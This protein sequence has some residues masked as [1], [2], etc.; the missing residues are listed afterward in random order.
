FLRRGK[1]ADVLPD[2]EIRWC[3]TVPAIWTEVEKQFMRRAAHDAGLI[4]QIDD[5]RLIIVL[6]PEAAAVA[7]IKDKRVALPDG[8]SFMLVDAGGGTVD[9]TVHLLKDGHLA[10]LAQG[11]GA[12]C[13]A[14]YLDA[15]FQRFMRDLLGGRAFDRLVNERPT[16]WHSVLRH[17]ENA[18]RTYGPGYSSFHL[19]IEMALLKI[20]KHERPNFEEVLGR[21]QG[22]VDDAVVLSPERMEKIFKPVLD[23]VVE[24]VRA[25]FDILT[26]A[27]APKVQNIVLVGGF[28]ESTALQARLRAEFGSQGC[29]VLV[30]ERPGSTI[31]LGAAHLGFDTGRIR[32]RAARLTYGCASSEAFESGVDPEDFKFWN[33]IKNQEFCRNR[34]SRM[35]SVGQ[36]LV[37]EECVSN[38]YYTTSKR[39]STVRFDFYST[40]ARDARYVTEPGLT[41]IGSLTVTLTRPSDASQRV[42]VHLYFGQ[43]EIRVEAFDATGSK[44]DCILKLEW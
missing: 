44:A 22:G 18:K 12:T 43:S 17:W 41:R 26:A 5:D 2:S 42:D 25:Q 11:S 19:P 3:L 15:E 27:R 30:P 35:V 28:S 29:G 21:L 4:A 40:P 8:E 37:T 24:A 9:I 7:C 16:A 6:E 34:F 1:G 23:Q 39:Q 36:T 10:E 20:V 31:L 32:E 38:T 13:G 14:T 33:D